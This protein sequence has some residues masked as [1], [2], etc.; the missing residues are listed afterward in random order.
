MTILIDTSTLNCVFYSNKF[1]LA[2]NYSSL[3][4]LSAD[5]SS[6]N[7]KTI[8]FV[9]N[10]LIYQQGIEIPELSIKGLPFIADK[11]ELSNIL[12]YAELLDTDRCYVVNGLASFLS[13]AR[14]HTYTLA[15]QY[16]NE[17]L[18]I[19]VESSEIK[20]IKIF[21]DK[22]ALL[23]EVDK[24]NNIYGDKDIYDA[25]NIKYR[26]PE[27]KDFTRSDIAPIVN[28][29]AAYDA[30]VRITCSALREYITE[31]EPDVPEEEPEPSTSIEQ[32]SDSVE[33]TPTPSK[34]YFPVNPKSS[35]S[36]ILLRLVA[37]ILS[38]ILGI[39]IAIPAYKDDIAEMSAETDKVISEQ[40]A[41]SSMLSSFKNGYNCIANQHATSGNV[42]RLIYSSGIKVSVA[43]LEYS[44]STYIVR[45]Y[46]EDASD[47]EKLTSTITSKF[48]L[49]DCKPTGTVNLNKALSS[50]QISFR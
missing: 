10:P 47:I 45:V 11:T 17:V 31:P 34:K 18:Y 15:M 9:M 42:Y 46:L 50:Y 37:Y 16:G 29:I 30:E 7:D 41:L 8:V 23:N 44:N 25:D 21:P 3:Q 14:M 43:S 28:L 27:L 35:V 22:M 12:T 4:K 1:T 49:I 13:V 5:I 36:E 6:I 40:V 2:I 20:S 32:E 24:P 19:E 33:P 48:E 38:V 26:Y 39:C